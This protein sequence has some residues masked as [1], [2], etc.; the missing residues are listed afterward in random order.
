MHWKTKARIQTLVAR[1]PDRLSYPLY[2][3][4]QRRFGAMRPHRID[5]TNRMQVAIQLCERIVQ[6]GRSPVGATFFEVG[7]GWRLNLPIAMWLLGAEQTVTVDLNRYLRMELVQEDLAYLR[8]HRDAMAGMFAGAL[9]ELFDRTRFAQLL[10]AHPTS[11]EEFCQLIAARYIAPGDAARTPL[12][13]DS[14]DFHVSCNVLEH[15]PQQV[16]A[17]IFAEAN[18]IVR[19][20]GLLL[21]RVDHSD[22]FSH[23]DQ[24]I[25]PIHFLRFSDGYWQTLAG[26]RYG[27]VNRL[28]EDDYLALFDGAGQ[29]IEQ[30]ES[31]C[32]AHVLS[33]LEDDLDLAKP[34]ADKSLDTL[35]RLNSLFVTRPAPAA[36][37]QV[38]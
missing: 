26:N 5:P 23:T 27:Y 17:A 21:H 28:R 15:I 24:S 16:L 34:Y 32:D 22:H 37:A 12:A 1:L 8:Q 9:P 11:A 29:A 3:Q 13:D 6:M 18:R 20:D 2:Y 31:E 36:M 7:T 30:V 10:A 35:A 25:S 14:I 4:L 33:L 38:A 19:P